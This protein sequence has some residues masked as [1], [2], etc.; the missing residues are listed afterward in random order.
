MSAYTELPG[1]HLRSTLDLL[2]TNPTLEHADLEEGDDLDP[3]QD[4]S[5]LHDPRSLR[6]ILSTC[7]Y[8]LYNGSNDYNS[9]D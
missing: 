1:H 2:E 8:Y 7:E 3:D 5:G 4:F 6:H 9:D